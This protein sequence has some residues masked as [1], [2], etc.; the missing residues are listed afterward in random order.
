MIPN[1][2]ANPSKKGDKDFAR[3]TLHCSWQWLGQDPLVHRAEFI[4]AAP[5]SKTENPGGE[6]S[7]HPRG[8]DAF[9]LLSHL[10]PVPQLLILQQALNTF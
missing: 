8:A 4:L 7:F 2:I 1:R 5:V 6:I 10:S 9:G 3:Q